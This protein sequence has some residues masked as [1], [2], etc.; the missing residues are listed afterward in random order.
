[1]L[2][3]AATEDD[4]DSIAE[5][6]NHFIV[7]TAIHFA[8]EPVAATE[9]REQWVRHRSIY[10]FVVAE[11]ERNV[12]GFARA[13][14]WRERAAYAWTPECSV[15][16]QDDH[17]RRGVGK[18][19]YA[20]L[21]HIMSAQGFHSVIAGIALPNDSSVRLHEAIGFVVVGR[22]PRAGWKHGRWHDL[23]F[24][25]KDLADVGAAAAEIRAPVY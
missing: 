11:I 5:I 25:Q 3:R 9:L 21:F 14:A 10:P 17:Q 22:V 1:M 6:I 12:V 15:Y 13:G 20:R 16:V 4:F 24:W 2:I 23:G 8:H 18:A 19:L 7:H